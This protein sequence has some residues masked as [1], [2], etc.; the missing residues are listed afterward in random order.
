[1]KTLR[2][3][4]TAMYRSFGIYNMPNDEANIK[5]ELA[6]IDGGA[7][8]GVVMGDLGHEYREKL[9]EKLKDIQATRAIMEAVYES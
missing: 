1:M 6:R 8:R 4:K 7:K 9:E 5:Y 3:K 2:K